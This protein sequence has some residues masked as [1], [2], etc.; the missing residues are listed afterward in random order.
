ML[1]TKIVS[2]FRVECGAGGEDTEITLK[3]RPGGRAARGVNYMVLVT[4]KSSNAVE[5]GLKLNHGPNGINSLQHSIPIAQVA[6]TTNT[7]LSGDS[8][9]TKILGEWLH[10]IILVG[11]TGGTCLSASRACP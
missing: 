3:P 10:P 9:A 4:Q 7:L 1:F 6:I 8:D 11:S 5:V 2:N